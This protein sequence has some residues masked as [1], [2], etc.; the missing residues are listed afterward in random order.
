MAKLRI[1]AGS[2][3]IEVETRDT[4]T[5]EAILAALPLRS[6]ARTWGEEVYFDTPVSL[7]REP[8]AKAVVEPGEIA[9]W[10]DGDAIAIGFGPTPVSQGGE[11]RLASPANVWADALGDVTALAAA[12]DGDPVTVEE[13]G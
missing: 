9:F 11:I 8:D 3:A 5:A 1:T 12:R 7:P 4:P 2:A 6:T 10:T 13:V